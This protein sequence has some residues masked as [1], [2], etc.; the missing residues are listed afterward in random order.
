M[1]RRSNPPSPLGPTTAH[2]AASTFMLYTLTFRVFLLSVATSAWIMALDVLK[3]NMAH[4]DLHPQHGRWRFRLV[5]H[6]LRLG[7]YG[8]GSRLPMFAVRGAEF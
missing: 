4:A 3:K 2:L 8:S 1:L 6:A 7:A 5:K